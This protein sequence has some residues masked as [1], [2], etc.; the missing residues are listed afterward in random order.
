K[1]ISITCDNASAND[2][3]IEELAEELPMF[4]GARSH[5]R[6]FAHVVNLTAKGVLRPYHILG[7]LLT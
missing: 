4:L 1:I 7:A 5:I 2:K 6:C 3:M